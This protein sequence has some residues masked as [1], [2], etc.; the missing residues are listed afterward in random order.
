M[1]PLVCIAL[2]VV[3]VGLIV[4]VVQ[5]D[6][7]NRGQETWLHRRRVEDADR[8]RLMAEHDESTWRLYQPRTAPAEKK[9]PK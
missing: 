5:M 9:K 4:R 3:I 1:W 6:A 7:R 8:A 2:I